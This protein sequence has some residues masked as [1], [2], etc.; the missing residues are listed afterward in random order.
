MAKITCVSC[1]G[2][3]A[4][5]NCPVLG[6][7]ICGFCCGSKRNSAIQCSA[8]CPNNPFGVN[9]YDEWLKL[10][11]SWGNKCISYVADHYAHSESSFKKDLRNYVLFEGNVDE[12]ILSEA[13]PLM[14]HA[15]LFWEP[16]RD[17]LCLADC[18]EQEGWRGLNNDERMMMAFKRRT[19]PV[20]LELQE[21]INDTAMLCIDLLDPEKK[22]FT[23]YDRSMAAR[24]SRF[25][26]SLNMVCR[27]PY[28][29]RV[30]PT[31]IELQHELTES[32]LEEMGTPSKA[33]GIS[34]RDYLS[35]H[36]VE[37]CRLAYTMGLKRRESLI[38]SLD[39]SE[40]KA[41]YKMNISRDE[42]AKVLSLKPEFEQDTSETPGVL[43]YSWVRRGESRKLEKKIPALFQHGDESS[44]VGSLGRL[45]LCTDTL[46]VIAFGSQKF[47][48]AR[49]IIE[50]YL[51][52]CISF[53]AE[54]EKDLK[55]DLRRRLSDKNEQSLDFE[56]NG[57]TERENEI[58]P[59]VQAQ[60]MSNFHEQHYRQFIDSPV[61]M[62]ENKT[63][64]QAVKSKSLRPKLIDLMK[65]HIHGIEKQ[66]Q[67]NPFLNLD[68][69]WVLVEL[70]LVELKSSYRKQ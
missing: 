63:P 50:K 26:R 37:S 32:F 44:G 24:F 66:N 67:E 51:G 68:I 52:A 17:G 58:P 36:F 49:K 46:E 31:G 60:V 2:S 1:N 38:D 62:L 42:I 8:E 53:Q 65:L 27:F 7:M 25:S 16:F 30:G 69:D 20:I 13:A 57:E 23:V 14:M 18:W 12:Y 56:M 3:G 54:M 70:G 45:R 64:R 19:Y 28:Y 10:D 15:K 48:F 41:V 40:W 47:R 61:P 59:E 9:N 55:E 5:R 35:T 6:G 11:G 34:I 33:Q 22:Q 21:T 4:K 29:F 39:I 43:E